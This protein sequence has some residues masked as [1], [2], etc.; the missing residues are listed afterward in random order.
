MRGQG[1]IITLLTCAFAAAL[2]G[3]ART[4]PAGGGQ[5]CS[6]EA[7]IEMDAMRGTVGIAID[8]RNTVYT[9]I[10][11]TGCVFSIAPSSAPVLLARVKGTPAV[12]AVDWMRQVYVGTEEGEIFRITPNG[13]ASAVYPLGIRPV[14]MDIDRDGT[15]FAATESG[16][17]IR[18]EQ[19]AFTPAP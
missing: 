18:L 12:I 8:V 3:L 13:G 6:P 10:R 2:F 5:A 4:A 15:L 17:V 19:S 14:G 11:E 1:L 9:A 7:L 16:T